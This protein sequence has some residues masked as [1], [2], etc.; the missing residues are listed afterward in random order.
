MNPGL[1][2]TALKLIRPPSRGGYQF[3]PVYEADSSQGVIFR[4]RRMTTSSKG[5]NTADFEA[6][7]ERDYQSSKFMIR[8][9]EFDRNF[10]DGDLLEDSI[11]RTRKITWEVTR[12]HEVEGT[13]GLWC[14][15][16][17]EEVRGREL[18]GS[19]T[20]DAL[21]NAME[22][23]GL[24]AEEIIDRLN[25][26]TQDWLPRVQQL[27]VDNTNDVETENLNW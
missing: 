1:A 24:T 4:A 16:H 13:R 7:R 27:E 20:H 23:T 19:F 18:V 3:T 5:G 2:S 9:A 15:V 10:K 25:Q 26:S 12:W 8:L 22:E 6:S 14:E 21:S 11:S 17:C